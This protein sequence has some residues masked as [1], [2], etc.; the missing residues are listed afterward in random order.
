MES[1]QTV[2]PAAKTFDSGSVQKFAEL[3]GDINPIHTDAIAS[4]RSLAGARIVYGFYLLLWLLNELAQTTAAS[5]SLQALEVQ[6]RNVVYVGERVDARLIESSEKSRR[7]RLRVGDVIVA[8]IAVTFG[9]PG[10]SRTVLA[11]QSTVIDVE[12]ARDLSLDQISG[13]SGAVSTAAD[14]DALR[15]MFGAAIGW[16]GFEARAQL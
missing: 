5:E 16:L 13:L 10:P 9:N 15:E 1:G 4:R 3:S 2:M 6:F 14:P 8:D 12:R 7:H 11:R